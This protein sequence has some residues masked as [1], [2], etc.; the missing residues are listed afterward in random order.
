VLHSTDDIDHAADA[1]AFAVR[2]AQAKTRIL[3]VNHE[4]RTQC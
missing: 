4:L 2:N 3:E 1:L